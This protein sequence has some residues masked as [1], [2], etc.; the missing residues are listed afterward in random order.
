MSESTAAVVCRTCGTPYVGA[1]C[2]VCGQA[3]AEDRVVVHDEPGF[4]APTPTLDPAVGP[5]RAPGRGLLAE[6]VV[7]MVAFWVPVTVAA[8]VGFIESRAGD[9]TSRFPIIIHGHP[10]ENVVI[11]SLAYATLGAVVPVT[12]LLL[13]RSGETSRSL[14]LLPITLRRDALP[15]VGL[16][17]SA[18]GAAL[19]LVLILGLI[20]GVVRI[21][22]YAPS[23]ANLPAVYVIEALVV[24]LVTAITEETVMNGFFVTRLEQLG[25]RRGW[26]FAL[27]AF[28]RM[29]Y[30]SYYGVG[31]VLTIPFTLIMTSDFIRKRRLARVI[32]A[33]AVYDFTLL[34]I[35]ILH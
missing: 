2:A 27:T 7:V 33:H 32:G 31:M 29:C 1:Y 16:A 26:V 11:S 30:H 12:L 20:P 5:S 34:T 15:A 18:F 3:R 25:M 8:I 21:H 17:A 22:S 19:V 6:T 35:S 4:A 13:F 9:V 28:L 10:L 23:V 24:S 14:G